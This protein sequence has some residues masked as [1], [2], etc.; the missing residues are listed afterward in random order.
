M[1]ANKHPDRQANVCSDRLNNPD[2]PMLDR[3]ARHIQ[4][5]LELPDLSPDSICR[6]VGV[7]RSQLYRLFSGTGGVANY[8]R[9]CR[10]TRARDEL[11]SSPR[12]RISSIAYKFGFAS[13]AHFSRVF[14]QHFGYTPWECVEASRDSRVGRANTHA[15]NS[16][17]TSTR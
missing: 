16:A 11:S 3:V 7:S 12:Q 5:H 17:E 2:D 14:K 15:L 10:L 4:Q 6:K 1:F 13:H 9:L 8:I